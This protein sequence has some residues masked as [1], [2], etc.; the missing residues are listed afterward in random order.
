[1]T[2]PP[3]RPPDLLARLLLA[4]L[5]AS[6]ADEIAGDLHEE[7]VRRASDA[8]PAAARIWYGLQVVRLVLAQAIRRGGRSGPDPHMPTSGDALM[9]T[10]MTETRQAFRTLL[11]R[12]ALTALVVFTLAIGLAANASMFQVID[13]L[14]LRPFTFEDVDRVVMVAETSPGAELELQETVS[15]AMYRDLVAEADA[16][17]HLGAF[18][19]WD[20]NLAAGDE[21][22]RIS[23]FAVSANF[24][25]ALGA[26]P[27]LGRTFTTDE[28]TRGNHRRVILSDG[29]WQRRFAGDRAVLGRTVL[30]DG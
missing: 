17:E 4:A 27:A 10:M 18:E 1:M 21:A 9:R 26:Q 28:E 12:P 22:E 7:F 20:V 30:F 13:A 16:F 2:R 8:G 3:T 6:R 24:F 5:P 11:K 15:P 19:W 25:A 14:I 29:L 23:G